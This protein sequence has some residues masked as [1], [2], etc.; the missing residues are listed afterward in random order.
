MIRHIDF[1]PAWWLPGPHCQTIWPSLFRFKPRPPRRRERLELP[2]GDFLDLDWT[3]GKNGPIVLVLHGLEGSSDSGY[4][5]GLLATVAARGWRGVVM[6]FRGCSGESNRLSRSY[7]AG[8]TADIAY[9]VDWLRQRE[10]ETPLACVGYS[11]GGNALLK[12]LGETA[13]T[14]PQVA[15]AV[16]VP[17]LLD[18]AARRLKKGVS[19][20]YQQHL[21]R[22][23]RA[24][25]R[26]KQRAGI[27]IP[28]PL[29]EMAELRDFYAFDD[30]VTAPL[31][32]YQGVEDY[33]ARASCRRY[34]SEIRTPTLIVQSAD[35]PFML[36]SVLPSSDE[37]AESVTLEL[38]RTGGHVG[39]VTGA[40]PWRA[41]YW[42]EQR[43][44]TFL[45]NYLVSG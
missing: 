8:D 39:F 37:L 18:G 34:L 24:N 33:Y 32:G 40:W 15:V 19:R 44:P 13:T 43:I 1:R 3:L 30:R 16:S 6:H 9:V 5:R 4:A 22:Q 36:P 14:A 29:R 41:C 25:Y 21:L 38:S 10:P 11:L 17:F 12:W 27:P 2:D 23:L 45:E 7:N 20:L 42:L 31:H 26:R 35:D 28:M